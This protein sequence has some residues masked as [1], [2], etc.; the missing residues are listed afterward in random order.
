MIILV[1][2]P[3]S[4]TS[5]FQELFKQ[6]N[7]TTYHW[8]KNGEYIGSLIK[9]NKLNNRPLLNDFSYTDCI[10]Q[11]DICNHECSYWPQIVDYKQIYYENPDAIFILNKRDPN[12]LLKSFKEWQGLYTRLHKYSPELIHDKTDEGF[13]NFVSKYYFEIENF[14][15]SKKDVKFIVYDIEKDTIDKLKKYIDIKNISVMPHSNKNMNNK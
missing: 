5:S 3:K 10:T 7:F 12:K 14:F 13:I 8:K 4:G 15:N 2:L 9:T 1:G 6:L 11:M